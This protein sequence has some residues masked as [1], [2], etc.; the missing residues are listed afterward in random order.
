SQV[1]RC[2]AAIL[3]KPGAPFSIEEVEVAPP[4]AKEVRIKVKKK[5]NSYFHPKIKAVN[6]KLHILFTMLN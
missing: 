1:I 4:K 3:W 2:R 5:K 6:C